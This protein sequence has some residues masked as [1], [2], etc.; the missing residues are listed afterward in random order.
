MTTSILILS[1]LVAAP[2]QDGGVH[3]PSPVERMLEQR[4]KANTSNIQVPTLAT[5]VRVACFCFQFHRHEE[6]GNP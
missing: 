2:A 3:P 6:S 1:L 5:N 4:P